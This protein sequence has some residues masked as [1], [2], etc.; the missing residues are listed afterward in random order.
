MLQGSDRR[1]AMTGK[2]DST[3]YSNVNIVSR[4]FKA[5]PFPSYARL[6]AEKPVC[7]VRLSD[8]QSAWLI[9]RYSDVLAALKD[10]RLA[11]DRGN[12]MTSEQLRKQPW[13]P[14]FAKPL[15]RNMLDLDEPTTPG[16]AR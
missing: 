1:N 11:K 7:C 16:C 4:E 10:S 14:D 12:A 9:T 15:T 2:F 5:D 13:I 3:P 6:R 8:G